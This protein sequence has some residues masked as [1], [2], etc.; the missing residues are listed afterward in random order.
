[1]IVYLDTPLPQLAG[2]FMDVIRVF[3]GP[4]NFEI[5]ENHPEGLRHTLVEAE[6]HWHCAFEWK[7]HTAQAEAPIPTDPDPWR[8][9]LLRKR[10]VKRLCKQTLYDLCRE[11][12]GI[13]P[14]WGSLTGIRPTRLLYEAHEKGMTLEEGAK[15]LIETY[16]LHADKA[17]LLRQIV[18]VQMGLLPPHDGETDVYIG[19]PFCVSRCA[20][21]SFLS[22]EIGKG[23]QV[24]PFLEALEKEMAF[25]GQLIREKGLKLRAVYMGGGTP[26]SL[27]APQ[28]DQVLRWM[29]RDFDGAMEYT[30]E[31]GR[32]D[33]ITREKLQA[34]Q[35]AGVTRISLN[36][37]TMSD[38]T[39]RR[40]GRNH[41][42]QQTFES[43]ALARE[44]G[45]HHINMDVI[46]GLPGETL[47]DFENTMAGALALKPESLTVHTLA[48]KRSSRL[49]LE[50]APLPDGD[51]VAQMVRL[52]R[53]T[54][55]QMGMEPYYLYRQKYMAGNQEN[56]GYALPHHACQYN[57][58]IMEE[59]THIL[60]VGAGGISKRIIGNEGRIERAPNVSDITQYIDRVE[61]MN[62]RKKDLWKD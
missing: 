61:E 2:D 41:T 39:L 18:K 33:T 11:M 44:M 12:T 35:N 4:G 9:G 24:P 50:E 25:T 21:C 26:T 17:E 1:M 51:M 8:Q 46:A 31:A 22:G 57:V 10:W 45:F 43:Y 20:Y 37:Q 13:H 58:D 52:G 60:A 48:I 3:L 15:H 28:L 38:E 5:C 27:T 59:T 23:K 55:G 40:I 53:E 30:V 32:P 49:H 6:G 54:A 42:V 19:I 16:D 56:V 47:R 62:Q 36:P 7:G 14:P 34:I 29:R